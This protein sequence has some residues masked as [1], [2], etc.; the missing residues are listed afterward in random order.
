MHISSA[1]APNKGF[2][3]KRGFSIMLELKELEG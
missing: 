2:E 3:L 1:E